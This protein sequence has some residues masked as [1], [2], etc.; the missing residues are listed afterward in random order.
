MFPHD[1]PLLLYT[2]PAPHTVVPSVMTPQHAKLSAMQGDRRRSKRLSVQQTITLNLGNGAGV[3]SA[4]SENMSSGG[5][6]LYCDRFISPGSEL[7]LIVVLPLE[8]TQGVAVQMW[9]SGKVRRVEKELRQGKFGIAVEFLT[10][11]ALPSA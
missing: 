9:C 10:L 5:A 4:V 11:Q 1:E 2:N 6:L 3:T 7:S 8:L